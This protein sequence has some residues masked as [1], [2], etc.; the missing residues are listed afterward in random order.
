MSL[1][2]A[3]RRALRQR[4]VPAMH[5]RYEDL[6]SDVVGVARALRAFAP[7]LGLLNPA[8]CGAGHLCATTANRKYRPLAS[9]LRTQPSMDL[10]SR[11]RLSEAEVREEVEL[12]YAREGSLAFRYGG[13]LARDH[14]A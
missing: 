13:A 5:V 2:R 6:V 14:D 8:C 1:L 4:V 12:G 7:E 3:S 9:F 10:S 11:A